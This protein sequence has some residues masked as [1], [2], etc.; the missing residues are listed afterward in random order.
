MTVIL[1]VFLILASAGF[2]ADLA[3]HV[4]S[5]AR[6]TAH[7]SELG[8]FIFPGII[9]VWLPAVLVMTRLTRD[10]KQKDLWK[11]ALRGCP[12]WVPRA[13]YFTL[14]YAFLAMFALPALYGGDRNSQS[15]SLRGV[16]AIALVFYGT[17]IAIL[18]S[19]IRADQ[20]DESRRCPNGHPTGPLSKYCEECGAAMELPANKPNE[21]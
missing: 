7:A 6:S 17:A 3:V 20:F 15:N 12:A 10:F 1:Y 11:A 2:V 14:G 21:G 16:S 18:Y 5:L 9:V 4:M 8:K 13:Q 19:A